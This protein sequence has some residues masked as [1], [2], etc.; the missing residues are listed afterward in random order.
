MVGIVTLRRTNAENV[1]FALYLGE[2]NLR[3]LPVEKF[4]KLQPPAGPLGAEARPTVRTVVAKRENWTLSRGQ[5]KDIKNGVV[6]FGNTEASSF[7]VTNNG[8]LPENFQVS[9]L[10]VI[11]TP[12]AVDKGAKA[13]TF[14][15]AIPP[16][17]LRPGGIT[18]P[19]I[20]PKSKVGGGKSG[21]PSPPAGTAPALLAIRFTGGPTD[22][23]IMVGE[24][25]TQ[26]PASETDDHDR[27]KP[28]H[29]GAERG[30][31]V[32]AAAEGG[33]GDRVGP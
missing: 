17:G 20:G 2:T 8:T 25:L 22:S 1:G 14:P 30:A 10:T 33:R 31:S 19:P 24:G 23:D 12:D 21:M 32:P 13:D 18:R 11:V 28:S 5:A 6:L 29:Q 26:P 3:N 16:G 9:F 15:G 27:W 7:W 4:A